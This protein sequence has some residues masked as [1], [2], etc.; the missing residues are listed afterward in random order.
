MLISVVV[1]SMGRPYLRHALESLAL[2]DYP[3]LEVVVVDAT[4]GGHPPLPPLAW[5]EGH[6][7]RI[8]GGKQQLPRPQAANVGLLA[9]RGDWLCFLDDDDGYDPDFVSQMVAQTRLHPD[10][11]V[12]YGSTRVLDERGSV[13]RHFGVDFNR[14]MLYHRPLFYWQAAMFRRNIIDLGCRFDEELPVCEDRDFLAQIAQHSDFAF[15]PVLATN[16]GLTT[17]TSGTTVG[18]NFKPGIHIPCEVRLNAKWAG[19]NAHH[20]R[21]ATRIARRGVDA[22][23]AGQIDVARGFFEQLLHQYPDDPNALNGLARVALHQGDAVGA[24]AH[25]NR[26]VDVNPMVAEYRL[27]LA[28]AYRVAGQFDAAQAH[29]LQVIDDGQL[30]AAAEALLQLLPSIAAASL[31]TTLG[32]ATAAAPSIGGGAPSRLSPC[33]CGSGLRYKDCCGRIGGKRDATDPL[34]ARVHHAKLLFDSGEAQAALS[35]VQSI[36]AHALTEASAAATIGRILLELGDAATSR[37]YLV[38]A[39]ELEATHVDAAELLQRCSNVLCAPLFAQ[40]VYRMATQLRERIRARPFRG[41]ATDHT[42]HVLATL[43]SLGGSERHAINLVRVLARHMKVQLWTTSPCHPALD[44]ASGVRLIDVSAGEFPRRGTLVVVGQYFDLGDWLLGTSFR[45]IVLRNNI[46]LPHR[47]LNHITDIELCG[48]GTVIDFTYP[49]ALFAAKVGLPG[50]VEHGMPDLAVFKPQQRTGVPASTH[51]ATLV[52][53]R[54]SRDDDSKHHPNDLSLYRRLVAAGHHVRLQGA[55]IIERQKQS[56]G[57]SEPAIDILPLA[58]EDAVTFLASL[59]CFIY[60]IHPLWFETGG[61]A[62][63]EAM[64]MALPVIVIGGR[65]GAAELIEH[66]VNGFCVADEESALRVVQVLADDAAMRLRIG[67]EARATILR[68]TALQEIRLCD[69]YGLRAEAECKGSCES[70]GAAVQHAESAQTGFD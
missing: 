26:A 6:T 56:A 36:P 54:Q 59:D 68:T 16:Y 29:A 69:F 5:R 4:G 40:S 47:V 32:G 21:R 67:A 2:Q 43:G 44:V 42:V 55:S 33:S 34:Q 57:A 66:G 50:A 52:I 1:R 53:G 63:L 17:G 41:D 48:Y 18:A 27:T 15:V 10:A 7:V 45:R 11:I 58:R 64:A 51:R 13:V 12:L 60:R 19:E 62:V 70:N 14:A 9:A 23:F 35:A 28:E 25:A 8:V 20:L 65:V 38:R 39:L 49:S 31:A 61:N 46:D 24:I 22:F 3:A 37:S 30:G